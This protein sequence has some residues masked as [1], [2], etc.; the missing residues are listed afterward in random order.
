MALFPGNVEHPNIPNVHCKLMQDT[1]YVCNGE[2]MMSVL[3]S[4][5][6]TFRVLAENK[7]E[8][9]ERLNR[10]RRKHP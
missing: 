3:S 7:Y 1:Q 2:W 8:A 5:V 6:A 10:I 9:Q 4:A